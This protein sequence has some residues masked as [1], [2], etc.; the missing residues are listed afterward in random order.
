MPENPP[1]RAMIMLGLPCRCSSLTHAL[2]RLNESMLVMSYTM[3]AA[4]AP[5]QKGPHM[6]AE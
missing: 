3:M 1:A 2:A 6:H 5:L 4:A